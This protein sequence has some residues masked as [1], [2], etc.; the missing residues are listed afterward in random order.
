MQI[1]DEMRPEI[2][3]EVAKR[4]RSQRNGLEDD[5]DLM[6]AHEGP[7]SKRARVATDEVVDCI[8]LTDT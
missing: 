6:I 4:A 3:H 1:K 7:S 5:D 2:K 8:D